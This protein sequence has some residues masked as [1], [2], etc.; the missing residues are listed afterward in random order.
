[1]LSDV[2]MLCRHGETM[3]AETA[4]LLRVLHRCETGVRRR[5]NARA[6]IRR[7][8]PLI[9]AAEEDST[10]NTAALQHARTLQHQAHAAYK[11]KRY[12][13]ALEHTLEARKAL[14]EEPTGNETEKNLSRR[15]GSLAT[16]IEA[17]RAAM[18]EDDDSGATIVA[19]KAAKHV[20]A[21]RKLIAEGRA[22]KAAAELTVAERLVGIVEGK[23]KRR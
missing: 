2:T 16:R 18:D 4:D 14:G 3:L 9:A 7:T 6:H 12:Q 19:D 13:R 11:E 17:V 15:A 8:D 23:V 1:M 21:A 20:E 10:G 22:K 5:E